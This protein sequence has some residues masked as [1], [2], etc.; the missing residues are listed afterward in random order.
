MKILAIEFSSSHRTIAVYDTDNPSTPPVQSEYDRPDHTPAFEMLDF[1]TSSIEFKK[2]EIGVIGVGIGPGSYTGIR[3]A[4][5][6]A[7]GLNVCNN[8]QIVPITSFDCMAKQLADSNR[9]GLFH[10]V[11]D[12][13]KNEL[14]NATYRIENGKYEIVEPMSLIPICELEELKKDGAVIAGPDLES[15]APNIETLYPAASTLALLTAS[16]SE[17][18]PPEKLEPIYLRK[19]SFIKAAPPRFIISDSPEQ[20]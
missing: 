8:A 13:Q 5:A 19:T 6:I 2:D 14:C 4:I 16:S 1:L 17:F 7:Q 15:I 20:P 10:L 9:S 11:V 3:I 18:V 12:A